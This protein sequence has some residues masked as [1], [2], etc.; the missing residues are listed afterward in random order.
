MFCRRYL[1]LLRRIKANSPGET[2]YAPQ[3][4][5]ELEEPIAGAI[6]VENATRLIITEG[7]YL[8]LQHG[9]WGQVKSLLDETWY[10]DVDSNL[11]QSRLIERHRQFG[12]TEGEAKAW[13]A[14]TDEPNAR[15]IEASATRADLRFSW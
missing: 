3:F 14:S 8:L 15:I 1:A 12:K 10:V 7:N 11:R 13:V 5:R 6:V 9:P 2:V 4:D